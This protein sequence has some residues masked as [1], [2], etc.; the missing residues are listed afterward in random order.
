MLVWIIRHGKTHQHSASGLDADREL[1]PLGHRQAA[2]L[3]AEFAGRPD[4][5]GV[6]IA[7]PFVRAQETALG[8]AA[9]T[10]LTVET[11]PALESGQGPAGVLA[12]LRERAL[13][14]TVAVVGHN[15]ELSLVV[16][17]LAAACPSGALRTGEAVGIE[18]DG[19]LGTV[20]EALRLAE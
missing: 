1:K 12:L 16:E 18:H 7:S 10:G 14:P 17:A 4:A 5:P 13:G 6:L 8:I 3:G 15:P 2:Y 11:H 20:F 9:M 19:S